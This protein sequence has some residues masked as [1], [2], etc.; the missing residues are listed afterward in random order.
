MNVRLRDIPHLMLEST[1]RRNFSS[2]N[3]ARVDDFVMSWNWGRCLLGRITVEDENYL[4]R[5]V[6]Q[7]LDLAPWPNEHP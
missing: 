7:D 3:V 6:Y 5:G 4:E 1:Q 2:R